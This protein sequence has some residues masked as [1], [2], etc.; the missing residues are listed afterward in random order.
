MGAPE[1]IRVCS[2][3]KFHATVAGLLSPF[4]QYLSYH[5]RLPFNTAPGSNLETPV[6]VLYLRTKFPVDRRWAFLFDR[7]VDIVAEGTGDGR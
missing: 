6:P 5:S 1:I 4:S 2:V 3:S 7:L